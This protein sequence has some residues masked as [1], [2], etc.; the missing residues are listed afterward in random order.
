MRYIVLAIFFYCL[1][2][3]LKFLINAFFRHKIKSGS[4]KQPTKSRKDFENIE[5]AEYEEIKK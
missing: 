1:Y 4:L 2:L 3:F 5:D